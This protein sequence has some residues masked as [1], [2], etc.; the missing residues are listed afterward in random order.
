VYI[1]YSQKLVDEVHT[2]RTAKISYCCTETE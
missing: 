1:Q 2:E